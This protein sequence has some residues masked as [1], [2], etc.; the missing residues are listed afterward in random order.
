[1]RWVHWILGGVANLFRR[2][3]LDRDLHDEVAFHIESRIAD[4]S[5]RGLLPEEARRRARLEFGGAEV[6]KERVRDAQRY[7]CLDEARQDLFY[8]FRTLRRSPGFAATTIVS[9]ALGIGANT[10]I[11][12]LVDAVIL[13]PLPVPR[14]DELLVIEGDRQPQAQIFSYSMFTALQPSARAAG[15]ALAAMSPP[16]ASA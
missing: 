4:L 14:S 6:Y 15:I 3:R 13:K 8:V 11:F 9:L 16:D 1:V 10:G 5:A 2:S 7:R 12:S